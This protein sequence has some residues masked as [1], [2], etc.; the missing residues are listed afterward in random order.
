MGEC[1]ELTLDNLG[2]GVS[3]VNGND[4]P[5]SSVVLNWTLVS[6]SEESNRFIDVRQ[7]W[8]VHQGS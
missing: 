2:E 7:S 8:Q 6:Q 3:G 1:G 5:V 4:L